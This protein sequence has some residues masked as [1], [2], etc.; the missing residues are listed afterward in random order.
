MIEHVKEGSWP[1]RGLLRSWLR[2][3]SLSGA[4]MSG[5]CM[6]GGAASRSAL[7]SGE[8]SGADANER[9]K[10]PSNNQ[11]EIFAILT[12]VIS[13]C[14]SPKPARV[15]TVAPTIEDKRGKPLEDC[16]LLAFPIREGALL[17]RLAQRL[18]N[19][20]G[21]RGPQ[22]EPFLLELSRCPGSRLSIDCKAYVE[23]VA[24]RSE[25]RFA[26][27]AAPNTSVVVTTSDYDQL[28]AFVVEYVSARLQDASCLKASCLARSSLGEVVS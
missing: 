20:V 15:G 2:N 3:G 5:A 11:R 16:R 6:S 7:A 24:N 14:R 10:L 22:L 9:Q 12:S 8:L 19:Q 23:F 18:R 26:V 25:F 13:V 27:E 21:D 28:V 1:R 17:A 4:F